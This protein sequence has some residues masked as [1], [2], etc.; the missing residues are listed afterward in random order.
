MDCGFNL[1][2]TMIY[3][4]KNPTPQKSN[5]Y[6]PC[7]E[8]MFVFTKGKP[9]I[10]HPIMVDKKYKEDRK[11]KQYN[12][13]QDGTQII[14]EYHSRSD[15]KPLNNIWCYS[16]GLYNSTS[17]KDAF[18]HPAIFPE[19]LA[20]D[21]I[22]SWSDKGGVVFDPF[23]GSGTTGKMAVLNGRQFIGVEIDNEYFRIADKRIS[24][25]LK[26]TAECVD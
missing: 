21:H 17:D 18:R 22:V 20:N 3:C 12:K 7:F 10:F 13:T 19:Q 26:D 8:Y 4:K 25:A 6:Q 16:T 14:R 9:K 2:D 5:R 1:H 23:M 24:Q 15:Q 11:R